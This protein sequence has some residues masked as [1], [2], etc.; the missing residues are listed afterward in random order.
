M[1]CQWHKTLDLI[2]ELANESPCYVIRF[3]KS[4]EIVEELVRLADCP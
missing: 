4:G 2:E 3:D 1:K